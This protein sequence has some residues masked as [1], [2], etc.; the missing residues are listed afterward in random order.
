M[1]AVLKKPENVIIM[2]DVFFE[3]LQSGHRFD[4]LVYVQVEE[5][6]KQTGYIDFF[7]LYK[8]HA[9]LNTFKSYMVL[10]S[11]YKANIVPDPFSG[12]TDRQIHDHMT[13]NEIPARAYRGASR[14]IDSEGKVART[15]TKNKPSSNFVNENKSLSCFPTPHG[16]AGPQYTYAPVPLP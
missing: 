15:Y 3:G 10:S 5:T 7:K 14:A 4:D 6:D 8:R 1:G 2:R 16:K 13:E 9:E 11:L 12:L